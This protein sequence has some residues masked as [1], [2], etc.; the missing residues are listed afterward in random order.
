MKAP[1]LYRIAGVLLI[2]FAAG[3]AF[4]LLKL[5]Q[6]SA[7][8]H[9]VQYHLRHRALRDTQVVLGLG[10]VCSLCALFG[11]YLVWHLGALAQ[12]TP[13]AIGALG[14]VVFAYQVMG[15]FVTWVVFSGLVLVLSA[16]IAVCTGW[17]TWLS[18]GARRVRLTHGVPAASST[19]SRQLR[20]D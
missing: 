17:A 13:Q 9:D 5:W 16:C 18:T 8:M 15:I 19:A 7:S 1:A 20:P 3:N 6:A 4:F 11:A 10:L 14:W 2:L 12:S